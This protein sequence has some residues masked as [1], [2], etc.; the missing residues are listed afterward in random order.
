MRTKRLLGAAA[1]AIVAAI[2]PLSAPIAAAAE[3]NGVGSGTVGATLLRVDVGEGGG[4]LSVQVLT[5]E[6]RSTIDPADG[7]SVS[8][9]SLTP[10]AISSATAP[11]LNVTTPSVGTSSSGAEDSKSVQPDLPDS[12]AFTGALGASLASV[13]D[14]LGARS[15]LD[16]A[17]SNVSVAGGLLSI[18]SGT[19]SLATK[20]TNEH[21][22]AVRSISIPAIEVLNLA[23][24]LEGAGLSL[25]SLPLDDVLGLLAGLGITLPDIPDPAEVIATVDAALDTLAGETGALTTELCNTVDGVLG[26]VG[27]LAGTG[28]VIDSAT[29]IIDDITGGA[30]DVG[31]GVPPLP[32]PGLS[33]QALPVSC[34]AVTGT[35]EDLVDDL[36]AVVGTLL[37][38]I[39]ETL[40]ATSLLSVQ[41]IEIGLV[42]DAVSTVEGSVAEVTGTIGS[43]KVGKL[44]V[45]GVSGLDLTATA[46]V[47]DAA[48]ATISEAVG[49]VLG[50]INAQLADMVD[51][52]V[53]SIQELVAGEGDYATATA[54]V[55]ALTARITPPALLTGAALDLDGTVGGLL[56][57]VATAV[58]ALATVMSQLEVALGGLDVLT[59]VTTITV[60][61]LTSASQFR[62][63]AATGVPT[64]TPSGTPT[65]ELPRTGTD[66][67]VPAMA[68]VLVAGV[69][70][71][72]RRY[73]LSLAARMG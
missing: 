64:G 35:V 7:S 13:V 43:V 11:A 66:A 73:V 18:P 19:V 8:S 60:G 52:E 65:G 17:L 38:S 3:A 15:G 28:D 67:A 71:G 29:D 51:V 53:L 10:L 45:P 61:Q 55:T 30:G 21:S 56:G 37:T 47:L 20:A 68:A 16:A 63:V 36:R 46:S 70:L 26:A 58:P 69:A 14:A 44:T 34:E 32:I 5:D 62:P 59:S 23:A 31:G 25:A 22:S 6:G 24:V 33:A 50:V 2:A 49:D 42:A 9:T 72:I 4:I 57:E 54:S 40:G 12:P 48:G 41:G 27:G 39:L 1:A